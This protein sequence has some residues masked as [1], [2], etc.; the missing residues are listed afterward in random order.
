MDY[1]SL[2]SNS[3]GLIDG[4]G[5][6]VLVTDA[7]K[8]FVESP[9]SSDDL[10]KMPVIS[11]TPVVN[12]IPIFDTTKTLKGNFTVGSEANQIPQM[13]PSGKLP[14]KILPAQTIVTVRTFAFP[15]SWQQDKIWPYI[16]ANWTQ[17]GKIPEP[18]GGE[19][20]IQCKALTYDGTMP[21]PPNEQL[22]LDELMVYTAQGDWKLHESW[23]HR[24][25]E[26]EVMSVNG[27]TGVVVI[28]AD[29]IPDGQTN[30]YCTDALV[31][32]LPTITKALADILLRAIAPAATTSGKVPQ[33]DATAKTLKD[34]LIVVSASAGAGDAGKLVLLNGVGK[35]DNSM[36]PSIGAFKTINTI[37]PDG[38]GEFKI[39]PGSGITVTPGINSITIGCT[40]TGIKKYNKSFTNTDIV[41]GKITIPHNLNTTQI[42]ISVTNGSANIVWPD[43]NIKDANNIILDFTNLVPLTGTYTVTVIG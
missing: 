16:V 11:G 8:N 36:L 10:V 6:K 12:Q 14:V 37:A 5:K 29:D 15:K 35:I 40:V 3:I 31:K 33:W 4:T 38:S 18:K 1:N 28:D 20:I 39:I 19:L 32:V 21:V 17:G 27:H 9:V 34:G 23:V 7:N 30:H 22:K 42:T 26:N 13:D 2:K 41:T 24:A 43:I 25:I